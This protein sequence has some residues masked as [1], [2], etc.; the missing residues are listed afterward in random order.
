MS[1]DRWEVGRD[2]ARWGDYGGG[3]AYLLGQLCSMGRVLGYGETCQTGQ[4]R[5]SVGDSHFRVGLA[6]IARTPGICSLKHD[7]YAW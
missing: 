5:Y 6:S 4:V 1:C 7:G 2:H 3:Y